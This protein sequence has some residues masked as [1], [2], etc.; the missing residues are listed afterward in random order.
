MCDDIS[1]HTHTHLVMEVRGGCG[2]HTPVR[3]EHVT[4]HLYGQVTQLTLL[5]LPVQVLQNRGARAR[6]THLQNRAR[7]RARATEDL[8]HPTGEKPSPDS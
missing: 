3:A 2:Q 4:L 6:E 1:S 5:A 7:G 8:L